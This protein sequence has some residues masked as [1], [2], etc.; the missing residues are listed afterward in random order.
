MHGPQSGLGMEGLGGGGSEDGVDFDAFSG[1][2]VSLHEH[3]R[4]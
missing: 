4:H 3:L 1:E 2:Q